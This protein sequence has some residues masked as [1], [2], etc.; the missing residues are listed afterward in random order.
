MIVRTGETMSDRD[1]GE[2]TPPGWLFDS[3]TGRT[4]WWDGV[5]WTDLPK[6]LDPV[7]RTSA[8]HLPVP[9]SAVTFSGHP[10]S[11]NATSSSAML[12]VVLSGFA[13][14]AGFWLTGGL[15]PSAIAV[16]AVVTGLLVTLAFVL[17]I[18][19]LVIAIQRPTRKTLAV[20]ALVASSLL[21]S[22][23]MFRLLGGF[24]G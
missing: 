7:V 12:F 24:S 23:L 17:A 19:A 15:D 11:R 20:V 14:A 16:L 13:L 21:L 2:G 5:Q 1:S 10:S 3:D 4:R 6:P 9:A 8:P 18:A 22:V